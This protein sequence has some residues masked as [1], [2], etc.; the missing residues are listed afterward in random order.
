MINKTQSSLSSTPLYKYITEY[1][2]P[3]QHKVN[4]YSKYKLFIR[5]GDLRKLLPTE[6]IYK[7]HKITDINTRISLIDDFF[8]S[9]VVQDAIQINATFQE[10]PVERT[11]EQVQTQITTSTEEQE[12]WAFQEEINDL[13]ETLHI[14]KDKYYK[15]TTPPKKNM[16]IVKNEYNTT[17]HI[18]NIILSVLTTEGTYKF[19][20]EGLYLTISPTLFSVN[21]TSH[22]FGT[23]LKQNKKTAPGY[24]T[25]L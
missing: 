25:E 13:T 21:G 19:N 24:K 10:D 20:Q 12:A 8:S 15:D 23:L 11:D 17:K 2:L 4:T 7:E 5:S 18:N 9:K 16:Q 22:K 3:R 14:E 6:A 1:S